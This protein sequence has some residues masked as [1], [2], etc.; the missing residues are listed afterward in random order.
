MIDYINVRVPLPDASP[1]AN[2]ILFK[3]AVLTG[4]GNCFVIREDGTL[5][6]RDWGEKTDSEQLT[7][8][9]NLTEFTGTVFFYD[10]RAYLREAL[11][12]TAFFENGRLSKIIRGSR[13][14]DCEM[15]FDFDRDFDFDS[16]SA[17]TEGAA[18]IT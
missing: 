2:T 8:T 7:I 9:E 6:A 14:D 13:Y 3:T 17:A 11:S 5:A 16:N 4:G 18:P 10:D 12:F 1:A 15:D